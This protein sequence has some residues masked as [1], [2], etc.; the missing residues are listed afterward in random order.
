MI[1]PIRPR[2]CDHVEF[3][4][5]LQP[6]SHIADIAF[7]PVHVDS[8]NRKLL[9]N[10]YWLKCRLAYL[11]EQIARGFLQQAIA[12]DLGGGN[13]RLPEYTDLFGATVRS[14]LSGSLRVS[15]GGAGVYYGTGGV[16]DAEANEPNRE[17][18]EGVLFE[19]DPEAGT[20]HIDPA[21]EFTSPVLVQKISIAP[22][23]D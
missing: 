2:D 10:T 11:E 20:F 14:Y 17:C 9:E 16:S 19:D 1:L 7:R 8:T 22:Q 21:P 18:A 5:S 6:L 15:M 4:E 12:E 13:F 23:F 3:S